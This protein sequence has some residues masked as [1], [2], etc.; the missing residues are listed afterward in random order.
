VLDLCCGVGG[1]GRL[2]AGT[3]GCA[4]VGVDRSLAAL[5]VGLGLAADSATQPLPDPSPDGT[6][7]PTSEQSSWFRRQVAAQVPDLPFRA[8]AFDVVLLVETFLA[9]GD[10]AALVAAVA[11]LLAPAGR[12]AFTVEEG[13][14]LAADERAAMPAG[15]TVWPVELEDLER[16]LAGR[17]LRVHSVAD[18]TA[19]HAAL[20]R[21]L[22]DAFA[23]ERQAI[24]AA[25]GE[26]FARD[27]LRSHAL[28]ADW[29]RDRRIRKLAVVAVNAGT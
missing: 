23:E 25:L 5:A 19:S 12:F 4:L 9:F 26:P 6:L 17:G 18:Q 21:R 20:A 3:T 14:P 28:W 1:P 8:A 16:L 24:A 10:K 22:H 2:V 27:L 11:G 15:D 7:L 13:T 29:L